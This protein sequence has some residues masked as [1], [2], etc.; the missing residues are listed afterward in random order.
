MSYREIP[1][2]KVQDLLGASLRA[3][4][5][6]GLSNRKTLVSYKRRNI[7]RH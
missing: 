5:H 4:F 2:F 3:M 1:P 6:Q 7:K